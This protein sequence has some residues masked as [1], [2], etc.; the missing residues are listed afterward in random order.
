V[1]FDSKISIGNLITIIVV[2][3]GALGSYFT[4]YGSINNHE[5]TLRRHAEQIARQETRIQT[6]EIVGAGQASDLRNIQSGITRIENALDRL[7]RERVRP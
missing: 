5:T 3:V 7:S 1:Q 2:V 4:M 6:A